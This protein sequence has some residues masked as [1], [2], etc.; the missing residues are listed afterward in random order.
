LQ[1]VLN[2]IKKINAALGCEGWKRLESRSGGDF[3]NDVLE[4]NNAYEKHQ[5]FENV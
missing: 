2:A 5:S 3:Q 1:T 4:P